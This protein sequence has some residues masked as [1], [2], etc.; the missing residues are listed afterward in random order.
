M[1]VCLC[2]WGG[3]GSDTDLTASG[4]TEIRYEQNQTSWKEQIPIRQH[5]LWCC[6][7]KTS[8]LSGIFVCFAITAIISYSVLQRLSRKTITVHQVRH[9]LLLFAA[10]RVVLVLCP[11]QPWSVCRKRWCLCRRGHWTQTLQS[12]LATLCMSLSLRHWWTAGDL[13]NMSACETLGV[14][15]YL[16]LMNCGTCQHVKQWRWL[17]TYYW[18]TVEHVSM[19][20]TGGGC[21]LTIDEL[22]NI[23]ICDTV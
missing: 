22:W 23:S 7:D 15:V 4:L 6:Q 20:N 16:L 14:A 3:G 10:D 8:V 12:P 11:S 5:T 2:V 9:L 19:W 13:W 21:L 17:S 18:W 1:C